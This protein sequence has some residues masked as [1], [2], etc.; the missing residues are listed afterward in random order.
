[1]KK[2]TCSN[3][4]L[5]KKTNTSKLAIDLGSRLVNYQVTQLNTVSDNSN[6]L[7]NK[8]ASK[9]LQQERRNTRFSRAKQNR[10]FLSFSKR[11]SEQMQSF[12]SGSVQR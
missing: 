5:N 9:T 8:N 10:L 4:I 7:V 6:K 11:F 3:K 2:E 12:S 1:M